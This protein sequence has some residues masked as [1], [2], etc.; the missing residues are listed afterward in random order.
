MVNFKVEIKTQLKKEMKMQSADN[1]IW[2][3][4]TTSAGVRETK[5]GTKI[6]INSINKSVIIIYLVP[7]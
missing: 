1:D 5:T 6:Q 7:R 2:P 4:L 3:N